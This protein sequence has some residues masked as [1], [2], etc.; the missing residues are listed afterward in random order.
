MKNIVRAFVIALAITGFA[1][2][3]H[4][5]AAAQTSPNTVTASKASAFPIPVC[6][7]DDPTGCGN[8]P[9]N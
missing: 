9:V 8:A 3:S 2:A 7:P 5:S 1:A 4:V 6:P